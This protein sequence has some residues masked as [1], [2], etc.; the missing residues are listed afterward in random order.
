MNKIIEVKQKDRIYSF[1]FFSDI[2]SMGRIMSR[3]ASL[4]LGRK[5][6]YFLTSL[7][8]YSDYLLHMKNQAFNRNED[9]FKQI[10]SNIKTAA[11]V[12]TEAVCFTKI[13]EEIEKSNEECCIKAIRIIV[14]LSQILTFESDQSFLENPYKMILSKLEYNLST[15]C[16][17]II[18]E[19]LIYIMVSDY[20]RK[21]EII[22]EI[23]D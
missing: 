23:L 20:K 19:S 9:L 18:V 1:R 16:S 6:Q 4:P 17:L 22:D 7:A 14:N 2:N 5:S 10:R 11:K 12:F 13:L 21:E 3:Y 15:P 8:I